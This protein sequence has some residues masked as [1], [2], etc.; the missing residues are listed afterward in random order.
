MKGDEGEKQRVARGNDS[1]IDSQ[2]SER[3]RANKRSEGGERSTE[4]VN[5]RTHSVWE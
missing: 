2:V 3:E 1:S 4:E 5:N